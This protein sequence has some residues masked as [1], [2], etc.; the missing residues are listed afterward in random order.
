MKAI[1]SDTALRHSSPAALLD[2]PIVSRRGIE[3]HGSAPDELIETV[4]SCKFTA[5][6]GLPAQTRGNTGQTRPATV[7]RGVGEFRKLSGC[8]PNARKNARRTGTCK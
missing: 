3:T 4:T 1:D 8:A 7:V 2:V 6:D 5:A